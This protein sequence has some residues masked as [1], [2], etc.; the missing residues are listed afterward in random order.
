MAKLKIRLIDFIYGI[1]IIVIDLFVFIL[2][3][4]LLMGYDDNYDSLEGECWSF[5]SMNTS[6]KIIYICYNSW[7]ILNIIGLAYICWKIYA[8][9][10]KNAT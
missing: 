6:E 5:A 9:S 2:L 3:G 7:I 8:R 1:T 10:K 4:V